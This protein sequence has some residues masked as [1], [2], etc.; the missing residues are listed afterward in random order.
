[1]DAAIIEERLQSFQKTRRQILN[2]NLSKCAKA[3][4]REPLW[5]GT[6][7]LNRI[8]DNAIDEKEIDTESKK[9]ATDFVK[10]YIEIMEELGKPKNDFQED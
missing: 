7:L 2:S 9:V 10:A 6:R 5:R 8:K 4:L 1:M 3:K